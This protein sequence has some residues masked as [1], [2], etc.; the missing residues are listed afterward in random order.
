MRREVGLGLAFFLG[1]LVGLVA[2]Q[3]AANAKVPRARAFAA[4]E[5]GT[6]E[7]ASPQLALSSSDSRAPGAP[8]ASR[9]PEAPA[10]SRAPEASAEGEA[11]WKSV[12]QFVNASPAVFAAEAQAD[13][14]LSDIRRRI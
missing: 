1:A 10:A 14:I 4:S 2:P 5:R 13:A 8:A 11:A 7:G 9:A 3:L 12:Q 6:R